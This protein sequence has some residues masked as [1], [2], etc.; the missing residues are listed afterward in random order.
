MSIIVFHN[1]LPEDFNIAGDLA[2]DT[3]TMGLKL[4]RDRLCLLQ[5]SNGDG[6]AYLIN[7]IDKD[8]VAPNLK[9]LLLDKNRCKIFHYARFDLAVIKKYLAID[10]ENIFCTKI[11]SKLARTYTDSHGLKDLCRELLSIQISKQQ[12][13]SYWGRNELT[14]E[15][16]EYAA[17]DVLYL[18]QLR[19][20][21]Q[22]RLL[23]ENRLDI[24]EQIFKFLPIRANLDLIGWND[25]DIFMH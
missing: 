4:H 10:L 18:H 7:F 17:K 5:M 3:E 16:K 11:S 15:Q 20:I 9:K 19:S 14:E 1:D 22:D 25:I 12:Q 2:I 6:N 21:L 23:V 24:A 8:Y 13:S